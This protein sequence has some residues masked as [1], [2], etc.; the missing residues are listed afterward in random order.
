[1]GCVYGVRGRG[2]VR[3]WNEGQGWDACRMFEAGVFI[4]S[5]DEVKGVWVPVCPSSSSPS[6]DPRMCLPFNC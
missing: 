4:C 2:G 6:V 5:V 1:M 3:V